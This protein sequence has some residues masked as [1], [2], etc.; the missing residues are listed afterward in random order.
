MIGDRRAVADGA[1]SR[2]LVPRLG[3][4]IRVV[5]EG[6]AAASGQ[7]VLDG[8]DGRAGC[9]ERGAAA[10]NAIAAYLVDRVVQVDNVAGPAQ[11]DLGWRSRRQCLSEK[12]LNAGERVVDH[13]CSC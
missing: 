6:L 2:D 3:P 13:R 10:A 9:L 7:E 12:A 5:P 4:G 1:Q 11:R 8:E